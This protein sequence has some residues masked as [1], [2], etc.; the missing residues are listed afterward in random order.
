MTNENP[1]KMMKCFLLT[2]IL[3]EAQKLLEKLPGQLFLLIDDSHLLRFGRVL[4]QLNKS[5]IKLLPKLSIILFSA[6]S[7]KINANFL[8]AELFELNSMNSEQI[9]EIL[10]NQKSFENGNKLRSDQL[11]ILRAQVTYLFVYYIYRKFY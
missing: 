10:K 5:N 9:L 11:T 1:E 4:S 7:N 3:K 2:D 8:K 6:F